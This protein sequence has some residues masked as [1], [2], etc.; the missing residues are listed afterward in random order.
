MTEQI[1]ARL[2][3]LLRLLAGDRTSHTEVAVAIGRLEERAAAQAEKLTQLAGNVDVVKR[4]MHEVRE[5]LQGHA[6][7]QHRVSSFEQWRVMQP[8][9]VAMATDV[10]NIKRALQLDE[11]QQQQETTYRK[12]MRA[13]LNWLA[14]LGAAVILGIP[15]YE[16][17][18]KHVWLPW[19]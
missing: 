12:G 18:E 19:Q 5:T 13:P 15:V 9:L 2:D 10:G 3:E 8:D 4:G 14:A 16:F 11:Q 17:L 7:L 1:V 6:D